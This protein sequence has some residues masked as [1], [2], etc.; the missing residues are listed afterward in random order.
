VSFIVNHLQKKYLGGKG[1]HVINFPLEPDTPFS[2]PVVKDDPVD[3]PNVEP[4]E[5]AQV[6]P[7][8]I[9][10]DNSKDKNNKKK[11]HAVTG[12]MRRRG[13]ISSEPLESSSY[14]KRVVPKTPDQQVCAIY[15]RSTR[16]HFHKQTSASLLRLVPFANSSCAKY[17]V[18]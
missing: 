8:A 5:E 16:V 18:Y 2:L 17:Y 14:V 9:F 12:S 7:A 13:A 1:F 6:I 3:T 11:K 10:T 4:E 15:L